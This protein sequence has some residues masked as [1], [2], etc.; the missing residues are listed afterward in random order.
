MR[1]LSF[2]LFAVIWVVNGKDC[3]DEVDFCDSIVEDKTC[4]LYVSKVKCRYSC[5]LCNDCVDKVDFCDTIVRDDICYLYV[6]KVN[7]RYSCKLCN[8][9][10]DTNPYCERSFY[11]CS[12][13][14]QL[15][16]LCMRT[17]E[18]CV[19]T[20][21]PSAKGTRT[22]QTT[23]SPR[24]PTATPEQEGR[25][26][27]AEEEVPTAQPPGTPP[28]LSC[29]NVRNQ[30]LTPENRRVIINKHNQLR[31]KLAKGT[32]KD[33]SGRRLMGGKNIY[34][35]RWDCD[36]EQRA[37]DWADRCKYGHSTYEYR[38]QAGEN[39]YMWMIDRHES[40]GEMAFSNSLLTLSKLRLPF[41][42]RDY[43]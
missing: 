38:N 32:V 23:M 27:E 26:T 28:P 30:K 29:R 34:Q 33:A 14:P 16:H 36:M 6:S 7:C 40:I 41:G 39:I 15:V 22:T 18:R 17:C 42:V 10:N 35:L 19:Q 11:V 31:S 13:Y 20:T 25:T 24:Q 3:V 1:H 2:I 21:V 8:A 5:K 12:Q 4:Y 9:C 43:V 37:Q